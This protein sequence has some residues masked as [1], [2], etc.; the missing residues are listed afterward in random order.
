MV[1]HYMLRYVLLDMMWD[2]KMALKYAKTFDRHAQFSHRKLTLTSVSHMAAETS[3]YDSRF[4]C[5]LMKEIIHQNELKL[6]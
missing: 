2:L 6:R 5:G 4:L 1:L 3:A